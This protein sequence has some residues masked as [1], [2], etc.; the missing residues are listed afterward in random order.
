MIESN[1]SP[2][3][4]DALEVHPVCYLEEYDCW[5]QCDPDEA[6]MWSLYGHLNT[7]GL[8]CIG[9]FKSLE[10]AEEVRRRLDVYARG[11]VVIE[12]RGGIAEASATHGQTDALILD[13][14]CLEFAEEELIW[15]VIAEVNAA[16]IKRRQKSALIEDLKLLRLRAARQTVA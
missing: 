11:Y 8:E 15:D 5:E 13:W 4:Y 2:T 1:K 3:F 9:D 12:V 7:G 16:P 14:D 6:E 10:A